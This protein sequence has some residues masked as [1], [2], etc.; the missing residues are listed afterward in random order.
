MNPAIFSLPF[1]LGKYRSELSESNR[2]NPRRNANATPSTNTV[3]RKVIPLFNLD[4]NISDFIKLIYVSVMDARSSAVGL[5]RMFISQPP[6]RW[7][8]IREIIYICSPERETSDYDEGR[9]RIGTRKVVTRV[10]QDTEGIIL[11]HPDSFLAF[12]DLTMT[13]KMLTS[14][15]CGYEACRVFITFDPDCNINGAETCDLVLQS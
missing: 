14:L 1:H 3:R 2:L 10:P 6:V 12:G 11:P 13:V 15:Y 5:N 9:R 8:Q 7:N 4:V